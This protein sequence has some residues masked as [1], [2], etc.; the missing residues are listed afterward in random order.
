MNFKIYTHKQFSAL[1]AEK[2]DLLVKLQESENAFKTLQDMSQGMTEAQANHNQVVLD[3][4][5][6]QEATLLE[7]NT[8]HTNA[9]NAL[10]ADYE[11][12]ISDLKTEVKKESV[13]V[14]EKVISA[15]A[16]IGVPVEEIPS[17]TENVLTP[18]GCY[19]K[20][21]SLLTTDTK[22]ANQFYNT[23]RDT[24]K[25]FVGFRG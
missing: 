14:E 13:S 5:N 23:N 4:R 3:L 7:L 15:M 6:A 11:K 8:T 10:K 24:I 25:K 2:K 1:E 12:Q 9:I 16:Q 21:Q 17:A 18:E 19:N 22:A 20:W